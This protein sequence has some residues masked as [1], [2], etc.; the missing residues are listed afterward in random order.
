MRLK[1]I[2]IEID[3]ADPFA[4]D[5]FERKTVVEA[6]A[7]ILTKLTGPFVIAIDSPWGTGKTTFIKMLKAC[8]ENES[9][10][11]LHFNAWETD[12]AED[13]LIAF[14][15]EL[16]GLM[17]SICPDEAQRHALVEKTKKIAGAVAKRTLPALVKI[18][19][20]G[21]LDLSSEAEK[22]AADAAGGMSSDAVEQ[23]LHE[24]NLISQF[25]NELNTALSAAQRF[26]KKLPIVIFVD[27]LDRC[28]PLYAIE[29]LERIKH[30]F[31]VENA[32][33]VVAVDKEQLGVSLGAVYGQG[34]K[35]A[36][37]L[38][39][40]FHLEFRLSAVSSTKFCDTLLE[41]MG[42]D[43]F[44][45]SRP[46]QLKHEEAQNLRETFKDLSQLLDLSP[47]AQERCMGIIALAMM[48]TQ[49]NQH[50]Y[51]IQT[52]ILAM[53]KVGVPEIYNQI[54]RLGA[55]VVEILNYLSQLRD[56]RSHQIDERYWAYIQGNILAMKT[57]GDDVADGLIKKYRERRMKARE[58]GDFDELEDLI[59]E[60]ALRHEL[61][62]ARLG[63]ILQRIDF[64]AQFN[65]Y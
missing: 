41:R 57:Q 1:P 7:N 4:N 59:I 43:E 35:A 25:H 37:Y 65:E 33:F 44:F 5:A 64:A 61:R 54:S 18:A 40:F 60:I 22:V 2:E 19:T 56:K 53:F 14:V 63:N 16:D 31:N 26:D 55:S 39:R 8:L 12:F 17:E 11:C 23:Y 47:R 3:S 49:K 45:S 28:R 50:F 36:E 58:T 24:K 27:E 42:L 46:E 30:L 34:F 62:G 48:A 21:G 51:P 10:P 52:T 38:R 9:H 32:V 15:G 6:T 13:P 29:L 20:L